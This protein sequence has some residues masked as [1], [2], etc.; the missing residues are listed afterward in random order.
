MG[1]ACTALTGGRAHDEWDK[2][3]CCRSSILV[4]RVFR[5]ALT[6]L[7][8]APSL[9]GAGL[10]PA[11][12]PRSA[13]ARGCAVYPRQNRRSV[14]RRRGCRSAGVQQAP[15]A[16]GHSGVVGV[17]VGVGVLGRLALVQAVVVAVAR[18]PGALAHGGGPGRCDAGRR[19]AG[20][21]LQRVPAALALRACKGVLLSEVC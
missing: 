5:A 19:R 14:G 10:A 11:K 7:S 9:D 12:T 1:R 18:P 16:D 8:P 20:A 3:Q 2:Q 13:P 17:G 21:A 6:L 15:P 4:F